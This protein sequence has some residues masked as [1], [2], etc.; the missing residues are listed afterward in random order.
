MASVTRK[1]LNSIMALNKQAT[2][3]RVTGPN[4]EGHV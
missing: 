2:S 3:G 4:Y 1:D